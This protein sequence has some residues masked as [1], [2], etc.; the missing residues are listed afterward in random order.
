MIA[1]VSVIAAVALAAC[2]CA[3]T[4]PERVSLQ[5][6]VYVLG[7]NAAVSRTSASA[8]PME[9]QGQFSVVKRIYWFFAGR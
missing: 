1:R 6:P 3:S 7:D 2:A 5:S 8:A 4:A 9:A